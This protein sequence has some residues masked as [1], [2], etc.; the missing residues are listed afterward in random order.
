MKFKKSKRTGRRFII[1]ICLL[2]GLCLLTMLSITPAYAQQS[3]TITG[4][5]VDKSG[6]PMIGAAVVV[7][8]TTVAVATDIDGK[9]SLSVKEGDV[10]TV[11]FIGYTTKNITV[12]AANTLTVTL[13]ESSQ[14]LDEIEITAEFGMKRVARSVGSSV[15]NVRAADI[16]D[17]GRDN[18]I[19]ALQGR[20]AGMNVV[21]S[22]GAPG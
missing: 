3:K 11:S 16:L 9:F 21:S 12:G 1:G 19:T 18:F 8:G 20:V 15:Q 14:M 13:E 10:L 6:E 4:T 5:V 22:G 2:A 17:S 7:K